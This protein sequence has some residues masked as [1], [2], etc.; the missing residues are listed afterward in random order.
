M[1]DKLIQL[2]AKKYK[3]HT[4]MRFSFTIWTEPALGTGFTNIG[5]FK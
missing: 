2:D 1:N 5:V 4:H 3:W